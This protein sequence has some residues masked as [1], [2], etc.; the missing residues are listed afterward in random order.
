VNLSSLGQTGNCYLLVA[1]FDKNGSLI[2]G[3]SDGAGW[4][5]YGTYHYF[6]VIGTVPTYAGEYSIAFGA[7]QT[8]V[9]PANAYFVSIGVLAMYNSGTGAIYF[10]GRIQQLQETDLIAANAAT[11][12]QVATSVSGTST[13]GTGGGNKAITDA[14]VTVTNDTGDTVDIII[15]A[16]FQVSTPSAATCAA[17][18]ADYQEGSTSYWLQRGEQVLLTANGSKTVLGK[19]TLAAGASKNFGVTWYAPVADSWSYA[20]MAVRMEMIKR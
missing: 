7:G 16:S 10:N 13:L 14:G 4:P 8:P 2:I 15:T 20:G 6:G 5:S 18:I 9:I 3:S 12:V 11:E 19:D 17:Y 1:F